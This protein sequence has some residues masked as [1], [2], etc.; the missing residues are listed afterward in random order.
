[1]F[2]TGLDLFDDKAVDV[3]KAD[4]R[5]IY[6][7]GALTN[8]LNLKVALFFLSFLPQFIDPQNSYR[9]IPFMILRCTFLTTG[10]LWCFCLA[11]FASRIARALRENHAGGIVFHGL[12][13]RPAFTR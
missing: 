6:T 11:F 9:A 13:L 7:Q 4:Y 8:L 1:V 3:R 5:A 2:R 12:G 10:T